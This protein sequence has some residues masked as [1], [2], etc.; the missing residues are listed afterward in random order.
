MLARTNGVICLGPS[1]NR[2]YGY[3]FL[4]LFSM[5]VVAINV[6]TDMPIPYE[7]VDKGLDG[8]DKD[9]FHKVHIKVDVSE[10]NKLNLECCLTLLVVWYHMLVYKPD[11]YIGLILSHM[12]S[13]LI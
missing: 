1:Y 10:L 7:V 5:R 11:S 6:F 4:L 9:I 3:K 2:K 13:P 8:L 12:G